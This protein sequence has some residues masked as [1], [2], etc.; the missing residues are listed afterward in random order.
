VVVGFIQFKVNKKLTRL[1]DA[2]RNKEFEILRIS[3]KFDLAR[4]EEGFV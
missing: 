1:C 4:G 2:F 3:V